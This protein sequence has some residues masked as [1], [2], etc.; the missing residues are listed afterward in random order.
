MLKKTA[1]ALAVSM[2]ALSGC[3]SLPGELEYEGDLHSIQVKADVPDEVKAANLKQSWALPPIE[4]KPTGSDDYFKVSRME[5]S[6]P[7]P[8]VGIQVLSVN[9]ASV[10]DSLRMLLLDLNINLS[11]SYNVANKTGMYMAHGEGS[12]PYIVDE[13]ARAAN[14]FYSYRNN[15]LS[16]SEEETFVFK[17]PPMLNDEAEQDIIDTLV[18]MGIQSSAIDSRYNTITFRASRNDLKAVESYLY[19]I[20]E[21]GSVVVFDTWI[22]EVS[23]NKD[24]RSG[25]RW[26][27][28]QVGDADATISLTGGSVAS[29]EA[30]ADLVGAITKTTDNLSLTALVRFLESHGNLATLSQPRISLISGSTATM[31]V[32]EE[33]KYVSE[34]TSTV[35]TSGDTTQSSATTETLSTGLKLSIFGAFEK[36][37]VFSKIKIEVSDLLRFNE[38]TAS[39]TVLSLPHTVIRK[40][41]TDTRIEPGKYFILG[42]VNMTREQNDN[43]ESPGLFGISWLKMPLSKDES[44]N[45]SELIIVMRPRVIVFNEKPKS[46]L[47]PVK[48]VTENV[49]EKGQGGFGVSDKPGKSEAK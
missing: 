39:G 36:E 5:K 23:L 3:A 12:L 15:T 27:N 4:Y 11:M 45:K 35:S 10:Y 17:V 13:I 40:I 2:A 49:S 33:L 47:D 19:S 30:V 43:S 48:D 20:S 37:S 6:D 25:V 26:D 16:F 38:F 28:L 14:L 42:G 29:G 34:L 22:W 21:A 1:V 44:I 46:L 7:I 32:G 41:Q 31:E 9:N 24:N 18:S 8:D